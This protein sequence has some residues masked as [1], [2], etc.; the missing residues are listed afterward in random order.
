MLQ[1]FHLLPLA[2][3]ITAFTLALTV[4]ILQVT[5]FLIV[6]IIINSNS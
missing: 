5:G 2:C 4:L 1:Y 6:W 3:I